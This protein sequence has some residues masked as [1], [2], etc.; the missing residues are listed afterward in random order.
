VEDLDRVEVPGEAGAGRLIAARVEAGEVEVADLVVDAGG[1]DVDEGVGV[2]RAQ[3]VEDVVRGARVDVD[4]AVASALQDLG[5]GEGA[6]MAPA[7]G[8]LIAGGAGEVAAGADLGDDRRVVADHVVIRGDDHVHAVGEE[9]VDAI[10]HG[11]AGVRGA[12][13]VDVEVRG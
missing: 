5:H 3:V 9:L 7:G 11:H 4:G 2:A 8:D 13:G 6:E 12:G 1:V 10:D